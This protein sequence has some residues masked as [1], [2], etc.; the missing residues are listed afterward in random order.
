[1]ELFNIDIIQKQSEQE[2]TPDM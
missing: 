1:L 2:A